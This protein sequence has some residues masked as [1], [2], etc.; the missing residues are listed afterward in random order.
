MRRHHHLAISLAGS[1]LAC[2]ALAACNRNQAQQPVTGAPIAAL[3]LATAPPPPT[4]YAPPA[5][6]LPPPPAP[7]RLAYRP[8]RERY[9]YLTDA[10]DMADAF[11]DTPPDYTVD[12]DGE[13]PWIWRADDG[14]YRM[15][16]WL[17]EGARYYYYEPGADTPFLIEDPDYAYAYDDGALVGIYTPAGAL[18][19]DR[20]A[21]QRAYDAARYYRRAEDLYRAA[22]RE[23]REA[24]YAADWQRRAPTLIARRDRWA[25]AR[26][27][28]PEWRDWSR[29]H[30]SEE[31]QRWAPERQQRLAYAS[32]LARAGDPAAPHPAR[33]LPTPLRSSQPQRIPDRPIASAPGV[34]PTRQP[35]MP[36]PLPAYRGYQ[37]QTDRHPA[38]SGS[39]RPE[40]H[41]AS[42]RPLSLSRPATPVKPALFRPAAPPTAHAMKA[43][44]GDLA[45]PSRAAAPRRG[46]TVHVD[47]PHPSSPAGA[48]Q[49]HG[50]AAFRHPSHDTPAMRPVARPLA[51]RAPTSVHPTPTLPPSRPQPRP[52]AHPAIAPH[53]PPPHAEA[54]PPHGR[55]AEA[56]GHAKK[57]G[58]RP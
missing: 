40:D 46:Q 23:Q 57:D 49:E 22:Q 9:R 13:R 39:A 32:A 25:A 14:A 58:P 30:R 56:P 5:S 51:D 18:I 20:L 52:E 38:P 16:E 36:I 1:G 37:S 35:R 47:R 10:Y 34:E 42:D 2:L 21:R 7:A 43:S 28:D 6:A 17:P 50:H 41:A 33:G 27:T 29:A 55:S 53:P 31:A 4:H 12:Y 44:P 11:G 54:P 15:V 8:P 19:Q 3:Q 24:A 48:A 26:E 45:E